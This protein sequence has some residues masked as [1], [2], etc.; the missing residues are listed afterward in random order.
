MKVFFDDLDENY[1]NIKRFDFEILF[2]NS[3]ANKQYLVDVKTYTRNVK[4]SNR[5]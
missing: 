3:Y 1:N 5:Y 4:F 2:D